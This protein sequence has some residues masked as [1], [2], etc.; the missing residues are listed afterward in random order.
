MHRSGQNSQQISQYILSNQGATRQ[1]VPMWVPAAKA[2]RIKIQNATL[3]PEP[4]AALTGYDHG[5]L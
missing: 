2:I 3:R 5:P 1:A 4:F